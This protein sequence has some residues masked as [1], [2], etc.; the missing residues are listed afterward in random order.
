ML[1]KNIVSFAERLY[2][3]SILRL[4]GKMGSLEETQVDQSEEREKTAVRIKPFCV[5]TDEPEEFVE[6]L[7]Q[8]CQEYCA[9][10]GDYFFNFDFSG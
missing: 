8:L 3:I 4:E 5:V 7:D 6:K 10:V 2:T 9:T 1:E